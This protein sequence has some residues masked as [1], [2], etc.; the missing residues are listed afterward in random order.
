MICLLKKYVS[1]LTFLLVCVAVS[2]HIAIEAQYLFLPQ[3]VSRQTPGC[4][5]YFPQLNAQGNRILYSDTEGRYLYLYDLDSAAC[6]TVCSEGIPGFEARFAPD[7][8]IYYITMAVSPEHLI[9]RSAHE[10]NPS[11]GKDRMVLA[12]QHGALHAVV[13]THGMAVVGERKTWNANHVGS[14]AWSLGTRLFVVKNGATITL[15]PVPGSVGY[16]WAS[17]SPDASRVL[18]E[19]AGKG[20]YV[21]D[22]DGR[23]LMH[24]KPYLMPSWLDDNVIV[25][26]TPG[27]DIVLMDAASGNVSTIASGGLHPMV[28]GRK[29]IYTTKQGDIHILTLTDLEPH[30]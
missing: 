4:N 21:V 5:G 12:G 8:K 25:A 18:F 15:T 23:V 29:V 20:L 1:L 17:L 22:L 9:F 2:S 6:I 11:T 30:D 13:G 3:V 7:G 19:A 24:T 16:L 26:Q 14:F 27:S 28:A 10:Y